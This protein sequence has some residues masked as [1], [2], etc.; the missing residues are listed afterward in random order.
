VLPVDYGPVEKANDIVVT[1]GVDEADYSHTIEA[2]I[3]VWK[4]SRTAAK[5]PL[6][7]SSTKTTLNDSQF[8]T[9]F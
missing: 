6:W 2:P 5:L 9:T 1:T 7:R 4:A 8:L 3:E